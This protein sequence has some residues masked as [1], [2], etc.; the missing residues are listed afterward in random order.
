MTIGKRQAVENAVKRIS[1][2]VHDE[3]EDE[4]LNDNIADNPV[5]PRGWI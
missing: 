1:E 5:I 3:E 2:D 4:I